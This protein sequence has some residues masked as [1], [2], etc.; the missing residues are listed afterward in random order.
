MGEAA[1]PRGCW[2]GD[3]GGLCVALAAAAA[4]RAA[5]FAWRGQGFTAGCTSNSHCIIPQTTKQRAA[6][7]TQMQMQSYT[8]QGKLT[9]KTTEM[10]TIYDLGQ[11]MIE[12]LGR[13][14]V[15]AGDVIAIDKASGAL[16]L[17][18]TGLHARWPLL[19]VSERL[20][21]FVFVCLQLCVD[22]RAPK[23]TQHTTHNTT[24][25]PLPPNQQ[26]TNA[27]RNRQG[28]EA[29]PLVRA[30]PRLRR[31]GPRDALRAVPRGR[32]AEAQGGRARRHAARDRR[33]QLAHA[34]AACA[35]WGWLRVGAGLLMVVVAAWWGAWRVAG[36]G[37]RRAGW[38]CWSLC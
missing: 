35:G 24:P 29:R 2:R 33:H 9:L 5:L 27:T 4:A 14:K 37:G 21:L 32:A 36:G 34:G 8:P 3:G 28:H 18:W 31:D 38:R 10:E 1:R 11:K 15:A 30:V 6:N 17:D 26:Q 13:E 22:L 23:T 25:A 7:A 20:W 19:I 16:G 12:A